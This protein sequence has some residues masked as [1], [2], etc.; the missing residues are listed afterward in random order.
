M[1]RFYLG[2]VFAI[3]LAL[4]C[5]QDADSTVGSGGSGSPEAA[6]YARSA[7]PSKRDQA[8]GADFE[9]HEITVPPRLVLMELDLSR[10]PGR[11][12]RELARSTAGRWARRVRSD[13]P[14]RRLGRSRAGRYSRRGDPDLGPQLYSEAGSSTGTLRVHYKPHTQKYS[15]AQDERIT[16]PLGDM[17]PPSFLQRWPAE[18]SPVG[19]EATIMG[20]VDASGVLADFLK[21]KGVTPRPAPTEESAADVG[22][23]PARLREMSVVAQFEAIPPAHRLPP[24]RE[25]A[26]AGG[27]L[28]QPRSAHPATVEPDVQGLYRPRPCVRRTGRSCSTRCRVGRSPRVCSGSSRPARRCARSRGNA[29]RQRFAAAAGDHRLLPVPRR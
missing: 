26:I 3:A 19:L 7:E 29:R 5:G 21:E 6:D 16:S 2:C 28:C 13:D 18:K 27:G 1:R 11:L 25:A 22:D 14:R 20:A 12:P 23:L 24:S 15:Y 10:S 8:G 17:L 9:I 4:G